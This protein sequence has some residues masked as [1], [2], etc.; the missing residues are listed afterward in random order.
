MG[1]RGAFVNVDI[2]DFTFKDGGQ[3]Y[4]SLGTL[5]SDPNVKILIQNKGSV[6]VLPVSD[7]WYGV[8]Y[9][10]DKEYVKNAL[11]NIKI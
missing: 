6:K 2:G 5:S 4:F 11:K 8:T 9:A 1:S 10:T 3:K 7:K